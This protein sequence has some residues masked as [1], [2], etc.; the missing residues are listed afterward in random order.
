MF[1]LIYD[2]EINGPCSSFIKKYSQAMSCRERYFISLTCSVSHSFHVTRQFLNVL[3]GL[4][5]VVLEHFQANVFDR[6]FH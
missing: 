3:R 2:T 5:K 1:F 6:I 4:M